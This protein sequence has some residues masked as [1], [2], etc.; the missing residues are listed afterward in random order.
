MADVRTNFIAGRMNKSVDER[1]VPLGE[2]IDA[3]NVRL[4][5][6]E[7]TEIGAVENSKGNTQ[8]TFLQFNGTSLDPA[9]TT[10]LGVYED[11]MEET[12]YWFV[13][14]HSNA[15]SPTGK[16]DMIISFNSN[17]NVVT[18]HVVSI[19][20]GLGTGNTTLNFD[21][22]YL[23]TGVDK[24]ED[25]LFFTDNLN[26]P[27]VINVT[28]N[29]NSPTAGVDGI[30]EEDI[31]VI[32][33]PP[34]FE[35]VVSG[36]TPLAAPLTTLEVFPGEENY[37]E[38][39]FLCFA[40]RYRYEDG[41]YSATS[42]F[43]MPAFQPGPFRFDLDTYN[44]AGMKNRFNGVVI[45]FS[46]GSKRVKEIDLLYKESGSNVIYV[47]E[48]YNKADLGWADNNSQT[49][50][51]LNSKIYTTLGSDELLRLYDNVP[52]VA[53]A[54]TIQGNRLVYG[55]YVDGYNIENANGFPIPISY[56]TS[57]IVKEIVG[58]ALD[59]PTTSTGV[60][61]NI[62][63]GATTVQNSKITFN[64][65]GLDLPIE[66]GLTLSFS[67]AVQSAPSA[68]VSG[69]NP[70]ATGADTDTSITNSNIDVTWT[71]TA[72]VQYASINDLVTSPEFVESIGE[73]FPPSQLIIPT[74]LS[75]NGGTVTDRFNR[76][77]FQ[78]ITGTGLEFINSSITS[79][80]SVPAPPATATCTPGGFDLTTSATG[81]SLQ[82][83]AVRYFSSTGPSNQYEFFNIIDFNSNVGYFLTADTYSL[84][85]NRD[86]E[87]G[88]V[89]M[90]DYDRASTVLV[91]NANT[92]FVPPINSVDK[93]EIEV[94][95]SN[96]P[97]YWA[98]KYKFVVK[99]SEG[100]YFTV[101]AN[102]YFEQCGDNSVYWFKLEGD[103]TNIVTTGMNLIVKRDTSGALST[104]VICKVLE[105]KAFIFNDSNLCIAGAA[106]N[107]PAGLYMSI[108]PSAFQTDIPDN[109][110]INYGNKTDESNEKDD[111]NL[112]N[113]YNLNFP[114]GAPAA[115]TP[116]DLP[117]G[118][119]IRIRIDNWRGSKG[120]NCIRRRYFFD[121]TF[122]ASQDYPTFLDW[123]FGDGVSITNGS[124]IG[125]MSAKQYLN[126]GRWWGPCWLHF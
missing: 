38:T 44:N 93:N 76:S 91:A 89:Y 36:Y 13:H 110:I 80:C 92:I 122:T 7:S 121:K 112:S 71:F 43:T 27:R 25:L 66:I 67:V 40:Y 118:S 95:L 26:A 113:S 114:T 34:G 1:L 103:N 111:C 62:G 87:T 24:L 73:A 90:D 72:A 56:T 117:A 20:D 54:Q 60:S 75:A 4:G 14:N 32:L 31:N 109:A 74:N 58:E 45:E 28:R 63:N 46:T 125:S 88:I 69:G 104:E 17:N 61:Y 79:S 35:D 42:L 81:F 106:S 85:S 108:K 8:L 53:K 23:V 55:N 11:G 19:D 116:Y 51:F 29:Y 33:K 83:P 97:P 22:K 59:A 57:H 98:T 107:N 96:L 49:L 84:H 78:T 9:N 77:I 124:S 39:R 102:T 120:S 16:V 48:R 47:I 37:M 86:Y 3:Q 123:W 119:S 12:L 15:L 101:Y 82:V 70:Q 64:L 2:Y 41:G 6:T 10:C 21:P 105:V 65:S 100:D 94:N 18:Y 68:A 5:S 50:S 52:R 30:V 99:P 115:G 126:G